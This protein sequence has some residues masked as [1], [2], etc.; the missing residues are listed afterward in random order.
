MHAIA[1][2]GMAMAVVVGMAGCGSRRPALLSADEAAGEGLAS[3][4]RGEATKATQL[5]ERARR[6][7]RDDSRIERALAAGYVMSG[8]ATR[9]IEV[10]ERAVG[11]R[12]RDAELWHLLGSLQLQTGSTD[13]IASLEKAAALSKRWDLWRDLGEARL[14][15]RYEAGIADL[16]KAWRLAPAGPLKAQVAFRIGEAE[17]GRGRR[18]GAARWYRRA[19]ADDPGNGP[20]GAALKRVS[21]GP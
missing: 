15:R 2:V 9:A 16:E 19:L 17:R 11:E 20:A 18:S 8:D 6:Q 7:G 13:G 3:L 14:A 10:L 5:L 21:N 12:P 4:E 1:A